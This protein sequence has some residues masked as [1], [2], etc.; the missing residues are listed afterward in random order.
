MKNWITL[1]L[2]MP[3]LVVAAPQQI[4]H[5][6]FENVR[7]WAPAQA[8]QQVV[9][10]LGAA[11]GWQ[12]ADDQNANALQA[13]G[14]LV[15]GIDGAQMRRAFDA[16][17]AD[18]V[19][20]AGDLENLSRFVQAY[21]RQPDTRLPVLVSH[22]DG[23]LVYAALAQ[24]PAGHFAGG[25]SEDFSPLIKQ[26][27]KPLCAGEALRQSTAVSGSQRLQ[28]AP[29]LANPM[30]VLA[31]QARREPLAVAPFAKNIPA[32]RVASLRGLQPGTLA[33]LKAAV[34]SL[35][36]QARPLAG[37]APPDLKN[38]P[39]IE[40]RAPGDNPTLAIFWS[41]DGGWATIDKEV[42]ENLQQQG[43]SV[44]GV[45]SLRYFWSARTPQDV[46]RDTAAIARHYLAAWG[47]KKLLLIG[48]SQ[49]A[50]VLP[51]ALSRLDPAL[52][53]Q[54]S[55]FAAL[56]LS[57]RAAF[58]FHLSSWVD[59]RDQGLPTA[60]EIARLGDIPTWCIYGA[61]DAD[62]VCAELAPSAKLTV[63]QLPG[64]H[65]FNGDHA[66]LTTLILAA[67]QKP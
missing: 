41:G 52:R 13:A 28:A 7:V 44:V 36:A 3:L 2:L 21:T 16:D 20:P 61:E 39:V 58:E 1:A 30:V 66:A 4:D 60:P 65:H 64:D 22:S 15:I 10:Y 33:G 43:I 59:D 6:R 37:A 53:R 55:L 27:Q 51:F 24:V 8:A 40:D 26:W 35:S 42:S 14:A 62:S 9:L 34:A 48:F 54:V 67:L 56:S 38:L 46:A 5:G 19:Y 11:K 31:D 47:K 49:G 23:A 63:K 45:D 32:L 12:P 50:D 17:G 25:V 18:C 57:R 29:T